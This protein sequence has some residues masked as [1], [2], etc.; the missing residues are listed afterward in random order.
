LSQTLRVVGL[1]GAVLVLFLVGWDMFQHARAAALV[2]ESAEPGPPGFRQKLSGIGFVDTAF[3]G[4]INIVAEK[5]VPQ[6][7]GTTLF[8]P[9]FRVEGDDPSPLADG[10]S[11]TLAVIDS[12]DAEPG[13]PTRTAFTVVTPK[14]WMPLDESA[15]RFTFDMEKLWQLEQPVLTMPD[16]TEGRSLVLETEHADLDPSSDQVFGRGPFT[17]TSGNLRLEGSDLFFDPNVSRVEFQPLDGVLSWRIQGNDGTVYRGECDGPGAF[18]PGEDGGYRLEL[19]AIEEVQSW[20]PAESAMPGK[21]LTKD[22]TIELVADAEGSWRPNRAT[23]DGPTDWTGNTLHMLG[24]NSI[25]AWDNTGKLQDLTVLGPVRVEPHDRSFDW[26]SSDG[27][28]R[29]TPLTDSVKLEENV[30]AKHNRGTLYGDWAELAPEKW[31]VGGKVTANGVD[32]SGSADL[33]ESDRDGNW[34]LTGHAELRPF[35]T[36]V[37]WLRSP[38]I[39]FTESGLVETNATFTTKAIIDDQEL[40]ARG[41]SFHSS[42]VAGATSLL[43]D[44]RRSNAHGDLEVIYQGRTLFGEH[45]FQTG[46]HSFEMTGDPARGKR[47]HGTYLLDHYEAQLDCGRRVWDGANVEVQQSPVVSLPAAA[48]HLSGDRVLVYADVIRQD[49]ATGIWQLI[50][51]VKLG[52][53]MKGAGAKAVLIPDDR[54]EL[55]ASD[56]FREGHNETAWLEGILDNGALFQGRGEVLRY[57]SDGRLAIDRQAFASYQATGKE[58]PAQLFGDRLEFGETSGWA[59][60]HARFLSAEI[61]GS[62]DRVD[63]TRMGLEEHLLVLVG[64]ALLQRETVEARGPRIELDTRASTITSIGA[65][66]LPAR[67]R[68]ADGR[69]MVGKWLRY[70]LDSGLF[71]SRGA[72]FE[73]D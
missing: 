8:V 68:A 42:M 48:L 64:N 3:R 11:M 26:A 58:S 73:T 9:R 47:V 55:Q 27:F 7:S 32:G 57:H 63:W 71:D 67:L 24:A 40:F 65:E 10:V 37:E 56:R 49:S 45:L 62:A 70:N 4:R 61:S 29:Y 44:V 52:G 31:L 36:D 34:Y 51:N 50:D 20:F 13:Q 35:E 5:R 21:L 23:A 14:S 22:L 19:Y 72:Q 15:D 1:A 39:H 33:L 53:A 69:R 30:V 28:A 16:F 43:P 2:S 17:M 60:G 25:I 66:G 59:E 46:D 12:L 54:L 6:D 41:N 18:F 38:V